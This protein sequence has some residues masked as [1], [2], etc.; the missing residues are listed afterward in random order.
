MAVRNAIIS[1]L[2]SRLKPTHLT[3][4]DESS[5]HRGHAAMKGITPEESHFHVEIVSNEFSGMSK[6]ERQRLVYTTLDEEMK[7]SVHA[8]RMSCRTSTEGSQ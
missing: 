7:K 8:I 6:I 2:T 4:V 5:Q 3:V 1:K